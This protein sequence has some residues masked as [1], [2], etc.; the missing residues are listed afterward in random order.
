MD[1]AFLNESEIEAGLPHILASPRDVGRVEAIFLRPSEGERASPESV[2]LSPED[3]VQGDRWASTSGRRLPDGRPDPS[4]Q[5]SLM[6]ARVLDLLAGTREKWPLAG[7]NLIV[8]LDLSEENVPAGQRLAI[9][10][11]LLEVTEVPHTGCR[12]FIERYGKAASAFVNAAES[13]DLHLRGV[14]AR[15]LK[16]GNVNVGSAVRKVDAG[17]K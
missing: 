3:G 9:D 12:K 2:Y 14:F 8:D 15:V 11:V 5:V 17:Q 6:N 4:I 7:D 10:D 13:K 16:A 1:S